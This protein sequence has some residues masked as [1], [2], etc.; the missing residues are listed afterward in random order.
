MPIPASNAWRRLVIRSLLSG[1]SP[2]MITS[3]VRMSRYP[4]LRALA[5]SFLLAAAGAA[6]AQDLTVAAGATRTS[7]PRNTSS[8]WL[9][10]YS[11]DLDEILFA[12]LSYQNEG[13][14]PSHHRDGH[15]VQVWARTR[16]FAAHLTLAAGVGPYHYFDTAVA[17]SHSAGFMNAHGWAAMYSLAATWRSR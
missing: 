11:H 6:M 15:A 14:V 3:R 5:C 4:L 13:H 9:V 12:S 8:G 17:E 2:G 1:Q 7:E 10:S 16:A